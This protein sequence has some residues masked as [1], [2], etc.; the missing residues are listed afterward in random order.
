M[1]AIAALY[2]H[3]ATLY[4]CDSFAS[5]L[6]VN[7]SAKIALCTAASKLRAIAAADADGVLKC[8]ARRLP[9]EKTASCSHGG[10]GYG[11]ICFTNGGYR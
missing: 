10:F 9:A 7:A 11:M 5:C 4:G 6:H 8:T 1:H 3:D 2:S